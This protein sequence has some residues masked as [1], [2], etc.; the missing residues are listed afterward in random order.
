MNDT[1]NMVFWLVTSSSMKFCP[2]LQT[3]QTHTCH[4]HCLHPGCFRM[5][6]ALTNG[7]KQSFTKVCIHLKTKL[8]N[9]IVG[10]WNCQQLVEWVNT[11]QSVFWIVTCLAHL[12][13]A[14]NWRCAEQHTQNSLPATFPPCSIS[15]HHPYTL[16][17]LNLVFI[18]SCSV[19]FCSIH[20]GGWRF[21]KTPISAILLP[22]IVS[23]KN[24]CK[25][26]D[27][28]PEKGSY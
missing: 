19:V 18:P 14:L 16:E 10:V 28:T 9:W 27:Y 23:S 8:N 22:L 3:C 4:Q 11:V 15:A 20:K 21:L 26:V 13:T 12:C 24:W 2:V 6:R 7:M 1:C 17:W 25:L 5:R